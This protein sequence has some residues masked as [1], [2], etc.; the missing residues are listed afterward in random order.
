[1]KNRFRV[2]IYDEVKSNDITIYSEQGVDKDYLT[3]LVFSN[4][5]NFSGA[6]KAYV[7]DE[8][9]KKLEAILKLEKQTAE[10]EKKK[11]EEAAKETAE[12]IKRVA[13][14]TKIN[15]ISIAFNE[16]QNKSLIQRTITQSEFVK[17]QD[18]LN[19]QVFPH[20]IVPL[21]TL[22]QMFLRIFL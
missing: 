8:L 9:K 13:L 14:S 7:Y 1:M 17:I 21:E 4:M 20:R 18:S 11:R 10:E 15:D 3:E 2:E 19:T 22:E 5:L 12:L 6:I 16:G